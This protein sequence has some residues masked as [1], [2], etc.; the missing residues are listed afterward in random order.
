MDEQTQP[1]SGPNIMLI[2]A[3]VL[4]LVLLA[5]AFLVFGKKADKMEDKME[6][7]M[8]A[9]PTSPAS[10]VS[11]APSASPSG[12]MTEGSVKTFT[13]NT[14]SFYYKPDTITVKKGDTVKLSI[15]NDGGFHDFTLDEFSVKQMLPAG[16]ATEVTFVAS[17]A[18]TF[19]YYCSMP[20]HRAKGQ[21]GT[22][23]VE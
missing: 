7:S 22:L 12:A 1:K 20:G 4:I 23:I 11:T 5:G 16:K 14:G 8:Q 10:T 18:G 6:Q 2:G 13:M 9:S 3:A 19:E 15:T 21:K 17:K